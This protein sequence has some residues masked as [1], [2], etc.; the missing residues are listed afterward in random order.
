[1]Q[2][3]LGI[4]L[5][6]I[7]GLGL[8]LYPQP[9]GHEKLYRIGDKPIFV[10][11]SSKFIT[12]YVGTTSFIDVTPFMYGIFWYLKLMIIKVIVIF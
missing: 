4:E 5:I 9:I 12:K 8:L 2:V 6:I 10:N 11:K 3:T 1:M 7:T